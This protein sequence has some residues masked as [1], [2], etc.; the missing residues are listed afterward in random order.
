MSL[1]RVDNPNA[2]HT[3][4]YFHAIEGISK[5]AFGKVLS[6]QYYGVLFIALSRASFLDFI[7]NQHLYYSIFLI[8]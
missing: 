5:Q 1:H 8:L 2:V 4:E 7:V 6:M 3:R